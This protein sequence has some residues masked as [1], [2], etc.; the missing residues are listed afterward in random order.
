MKIS[1]Y[2]VQ[3]VIYALISTPV[4]RFVSGLIPRY[5]RRF[6]WNNVEVFL[7]RHYPDRV[8]LSSF[9]RYYPESAKRVLFVGCRRYNASELSLLRTLGA[10]ITVIDVDA[11]VEKFAQGVEFKLL[12][13]S[14]LDLEYNS[15]FDFIVCNGVFGDGLDERDAQLKAFRAMYEALK[16]S[17]SVLVG[18]NSEGHPCYS[19][20]ANEVLDAAAA[21][22]LANFPSGQHRYFLLS[23]QQLVES[24]TG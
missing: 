19:R 13:L 23:K 22:C 5:F 2:F 18:L 1:I 10:T 17:G 21:S 11:Y 15:E 20:S 6:A 3:K 14:D 4:F 12:S 8:W 16:P 9:L 7:V 24:L